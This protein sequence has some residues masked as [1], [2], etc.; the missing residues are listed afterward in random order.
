MKRILSALALVILAV[1]A[2]SGCGHVDPGVT[3]QTIIYRDAPVEKSKLAISMRPKT[4]LS[5]SPQ[6]LMYPFW[7]A[8]KMDNHMLVGRELGRLVHQT[9]T[10]LEVF[11]TLAYDPQLVYRGPEHA[12]SVARRAGADL[13]IVGIVPYLITGGTVDSTAITLQIRVYETQGGNLV[14]SMDQSARVEAKRTK[15]MIIFSLETRLSDSP[16]AEAVASIAADMAVP[17]NSWLPPSDEELGFADT[18]QGM[19]RNILA[20]GAYGGAGKGGAGSSRDMAA[21]LLNGANGKG[22]NADGVKLKVEFDFD[23]SRIRQESFGLL[24][25]LAKALKSDDL[26]GRKVV[27]SGHCDIVGTDEYNQK[28][29]ERRAASVKAYLAEKGGVAPELLRTEGFGKSRPLV[30]NTTPANKQRNRRVEVR[31]DVAAH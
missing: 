10:G 14:L 15:D 24:N 17:L 25:E 22:G 21:G 19:T 26:K 11:Q 18:S 9:W 5:D 1:L 31:L 30:P 28:L 12:V 27:V 3:Q 6:V 2:L 7:V 4:R 20:S 23:S 16:I 29:S 8:Q 13:V